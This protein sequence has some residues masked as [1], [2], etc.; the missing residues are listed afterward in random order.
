MAILSRWSKYMFFSIILEDISKPFQCKSFTCATQGTTK[1]PS[2]LPVRDSSFD[3][4]R[5]SKNGLRYRKIQ[6]LEKDCSGYAHFKF[7]KRELIKWAV[8]QRNR[9]KLLPN[10]PC[11][12][13]SRS[14]LKGPSIPK[15]LNLDWIFK[16]DQSMKENNTMVSVYSSYLGVNCHVSLSPSYLLD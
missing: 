1:L 6:C 12:L 14:G 15:G 3:S 2:N 13:S 16:V 7:S 11:L 8:N 9:S 10:W 4:S 5:P